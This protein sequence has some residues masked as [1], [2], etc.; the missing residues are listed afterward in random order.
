MALGMLNSRMKDFY[1]LWLLSR[2]FEF[3]G[4]KPAMAIRSTLDRRRTPLSAEFPPALGDEF[5]RDTAKQGQWKAFV[6]RGQLRDGEVDLEE[7][8]QGVRAFV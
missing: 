3:D 8:V 7:V 4:A 2:E 6:S 1:D 5:V